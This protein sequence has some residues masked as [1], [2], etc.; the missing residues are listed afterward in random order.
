MKDKS[1]YVKLVVDSEGGIS[2]GNC[3]CPRGNWL[4]SHIAATAIYAKKGILD[5]D[6]P[7]PWIAGPKKAVKVLPRAFA[8][9]FPFTR[10]SYKGLSRSAIDSDKEF[11]RASP[12]NSGIPCPFL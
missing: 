7:N 4:C 6:L 9:V 2:E 1:Y 8:D 12:A 5:T 11:L 3:E 10:P